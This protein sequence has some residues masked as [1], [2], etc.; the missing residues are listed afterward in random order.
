MNFVFEDINNNLNFKNCRDINPSTIRRFGTSSF[1]MKIIR[2]KQGKKIDI[3]NRPNHY[4]IPASVN[5]SPND[6]AKEDGCLSYLNEKQL[7]DLRSGRALVMLDQT[8]EGYQTEWLWEYLHNDCYKNKVNPASIIYVTGNLLSHDQYN[9]WANDNKVA[10]R[11]LVIPHP[12]FE[13]DVFEISEET[14]NVSYDNNLEY[15][16]NKLLEIKDYNCLQK[17]LRAHRI[18]FYNLL[19]KEQIID[20]GLLS[21]NPYDYKSSYLEGRWISFEDSAASSK[22][23]PLLIYGKNN[24]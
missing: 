12:I 2:N 16:K 15:K 8:L 6:W 11:I 21:M 20:N 18:W 13:H 9:K 5:H 19:Y 3:E 7:I 1:A 22:I 23:L 17:R 4:I 24:N 14:L 10:E